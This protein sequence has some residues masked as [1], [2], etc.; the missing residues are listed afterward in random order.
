MKIHLHRPITGSIFILILSIVNVNTS[1]YDLQVNPITKKILN[2]SVHVF[3]ILQNDNITKPRDIMEKLIKIQAANEQIRKI[4]YD[5]EKTADEYLSEH[6]QKEI[7]ALYDN[8]R[9][10][11][12]RDDGK[13]T[14]T[15]DSILRPYQA[16]HYYKL[17]CEFLLYCNKN[18]NETLMYNIFHHYQQRVSQLKK[19]FNSLL[20]NVKGM[21]N[22]LFVKFLNRTFFYD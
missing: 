1:R 6:L 3:K 20:I 19:K 14:K 7:D 13:D 21:Y 9:E 12:L 18:T 2:Y 15:I 10:I 11:C 4:M 16:S 22:C 17:F 8:I 5:Y